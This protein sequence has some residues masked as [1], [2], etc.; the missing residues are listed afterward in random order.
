MG[1]NQSH[2]WRC[3]QR[4]RACKGSTS[5]E[6]SYVLSQRLRRA[7]SH[8]PYEKLLVLVVSA[9][10]D[11]LLLEIEVPN[12]QAMGD[13][14]FERHLTFIFQAEDLRPEMRGQLHCA[15]NGVNRLGH[16]RG[17]LRL[18]APLIFGRPV[19]KECVG[20]LFYAY[21]GSSDLYSANLYL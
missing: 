10:R 1:H 20:T 3:V 9:V 2:K 7:S 17:R 15:R 11:V 21:E 19:S 12:D 8:P 14:D 13:M 6:K 18:A 5:T 4:K 16:D